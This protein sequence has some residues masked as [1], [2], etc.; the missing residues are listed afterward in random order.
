MIM[1]KWVTL[2]LAGGQSRR[3]G[4]SKTFLPRKDQLMIEHLV[5]I[6]QEVSG[7]TIII[8]HENDVLKLNKLFIQNQNIAILQDEQRF[9]GFGPLAGLYTGMKHINAE[10]YFVLANDMPNINISYLKGLQQC[11][12]SHP[13][14]DIIIPIHNGRMH[15]LAGAYRN[16]EKGLY[17]YLNKGNKKMTDFIDSVSTYKIL[18]Q[19]WGEWTN[20]NKLFFNMNTPS[21]LS[22]WEKNIDK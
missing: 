14:S 21:D 1:Y 11:T 3:M 18:E 5:S 22:N 9:K 17:E 4:T 13:Q 2:I 16:Q 6:S 8:S 19:E 10:W 20:Q 12:L 7:H 15:P